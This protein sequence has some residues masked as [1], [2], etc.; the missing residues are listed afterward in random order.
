MNGV[1]M[2]EFYYQYQTKDQHNNV[3]Y[4]ECSLEYE[5]REFGSWQDSLQL[6][7]DYTASTI[8]LDA[9]IKDVSIYNL[10]DEDTILKIENKA[11]AYIEEL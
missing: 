6:E 4:I 3:I 7:P 1:D 9:K 11:Q 10:L 8:L 5:E 2:S